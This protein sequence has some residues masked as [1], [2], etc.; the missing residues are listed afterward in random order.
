[1]LCY[2]KAMARRPRIHFPGALCHVISRG[3]R[4]QKIFCS[5]S[6]RA[7]Y[8]QLLSHYQSRYSFRLYAYVLMSNHIHLLVEAEATPLSKIMQGLQQA[9]TLYFNR[10]YGLVGHLFQGRYKAFLFD[11]DSYLLELVRYLH[12]NPVRS[13]LVKDPALYPW[14]S[15]QAVL[16]KGS[17]DKRRWVAAEWVLSQFS[18]SRAEAV[19]R[20]R[21][22]VSEA[23]GEGH[24]DD[25]YA[26]KEQRC[27][28]DDDFVDRVIRKVEKEELRPVRIALEQIEEVVSRKYDLSVEQL[29][30]RSKE[31]R[32]SFG[33]LLVGYLG[34]QLG[35]TTLNEVAK[36]Y[37][38]DQVTLSL[39]IK[40]FTEKVA[41]D[42]GLRQSVNGLMDQLHNTGRRKLNN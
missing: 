37:G 32:G 35:S 31:R 1:M 4:R 41:R 19:R 7:R 34:R 23:I 6:D 16:G 40:R 27:L 25:L 13:G 20:Y 22:F 3:N 11:R 2:R 9:Y 42:R 14:S 36:R 39:G 10:K 29:R 8:L 38:R 15:H 26:V 18:R 28:G 33:R 17:G 5:A 21:Q 30:S 24:R 12:L